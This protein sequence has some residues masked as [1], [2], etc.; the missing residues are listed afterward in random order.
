MPKYVT[1]HPHLSTD[2]LEWRYPVGFVHPASGRAI[3]HLA[4][5]VNIP[6]F[7]AELA[8]F[9]RQVGVSP[10]KKIVLDRAGS[11]WIVLDGTPVCTCVYPTTS[12]CTSSRPT[13][14]NCS[15]PNI[16]GR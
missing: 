2:D 14:P 16:S 15:P 3:F 1:L 13:P 7:E 10:K 5:S 4:T 11:C 9:A 8:A 12:I 6:I